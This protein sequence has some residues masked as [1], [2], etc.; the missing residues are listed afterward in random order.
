MSDN[1]ACYPVMGIATPYS[2]S[3]WVRAAGAVAEIAVSVGRPQLHFPTCLA[4]VVRI[5]TKLRPTLYEPLSSCRFLR[6][7]LAETIRNSRV[8]YDDPTVKFSQTNGHAR[9]SRQIYCFTILCHCKEKRFVAI[10]RPL[11]RHS[12]LVRRARAR[13]LGRAKAGDPRSWLAAAGADPA[14]DRTRRAP[15]RVDLF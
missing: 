14:A 4:D 12:L 9:L 1:D 11:L 6:L 7:V 10:R 5:T 8:P 3:D 13:S 15:I 2:S